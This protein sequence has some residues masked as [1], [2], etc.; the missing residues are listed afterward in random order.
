MDNPRMHMVAL[1]QAAELI[2]KDD[3]RLE[4]VLDQNRI[5]V[6]FEG[7]F[8]RNSVSPRGLNAV[9]IVL[10]VLLPF[11][12]P[13]FLFLFVMSPSLSLSLDLLLLACVL[14][15]HMARV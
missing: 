10:Y 9:R 6:G 15:H 8:G 4:K 13:F 1:A 3:P 11:F 12:L 5:Q 7:S 2:A 14:W